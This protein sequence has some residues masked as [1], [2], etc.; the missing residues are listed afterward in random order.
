MQ[1]ESRLTLDGPPGLVAADLL[2]PAGGN[3]V[4]SGRS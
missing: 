4:R 2:W 3:W 1:R